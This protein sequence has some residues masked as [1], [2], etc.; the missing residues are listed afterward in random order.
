M[1][2]VVK[3]DNT[4]GSL[5]DMLCAI[6]RHLQRF[7]FVTVFPQ[8]NADV[9]VCLEVRSGGRAI[10]AALKQFHYKVE[11]VGKWPHHCDTQPIK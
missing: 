10:M 2:L 6:P 4:P 5:F 9:G 11:A 3:I 1:K 7:S 8:H